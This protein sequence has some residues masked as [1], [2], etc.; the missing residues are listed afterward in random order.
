MV[1]SFHGL[2]EIGKV[3]GRLENIVKPLQNGLSAG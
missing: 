2:A 1:L 3:L